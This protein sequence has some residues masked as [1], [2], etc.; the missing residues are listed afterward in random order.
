MS[1]D[2]KEASHPCHTSYVG[3]TAHK[4]MCT[5]LCLFT[6]KLLVHWGCLD[7]GYCM[8][9]DLSLESA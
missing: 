4:E 1:G 8:C 9:E 7:C 2:G 3:K 6:H 5:V